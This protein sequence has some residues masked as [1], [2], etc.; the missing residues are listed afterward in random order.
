[1]AASL[2]CMIQHYKQLWQPW[3]LA[4]GIR[5]D[6]SEQTATT[7]A[8]KVFSRKFWSGNQSFT[9][10]CLSTFLVDSTAQMTTY[11]LSMNGSAE[12]AVKIMTEEV[13]S[14]AWWSHPDLSAGFLA[15]CGLPP[16]RFLAYTVP[17]RHS[18][19]DAC[20]GLPFTPT[21]PLTYGAV[22]IHDQA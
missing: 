21:C 9:V 1:M 8:I 15:V 20:K 18:I 7:L 22:D 2:T 10:Q 4:H 5:Q 3:A 19:I 13:T 14:S 11:S 17:S 16:G 12:C 6:S